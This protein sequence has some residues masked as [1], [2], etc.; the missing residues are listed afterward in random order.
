LGILS[1]ILGSGDVVSKGIG[2]IDDMWETD[3]E[4]RESKTKAKIDL[5]KA[6]APFKIAQRYLALMFTATYIICFAIVL[7]FT[8]AGKGNPD[9][10]IAVMA[11]FKVGWIMTTIILFYFGGGL[12]E[13]AGRA[14]AK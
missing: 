3:A 11:E 14:K 7:G 10:V 5:M 4:K 1:S 6:Y 8:L 9:D 2:L 13:S 12:V